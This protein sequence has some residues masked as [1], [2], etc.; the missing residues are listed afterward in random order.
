[1][2][3]RQHHRAHRHQGETAATGLDRP[4]SSRRPQHAEAP[5]DTAYCQREPREREP[6][7]QASEKVSE[8]Q[9]HVRLLSAAP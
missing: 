3:A 9:Q 8:G 2:T 5:G 4:L 1:L 6:S 7:E